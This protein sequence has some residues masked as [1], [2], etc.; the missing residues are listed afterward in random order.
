M[1]GTDREA[2][3]E[4]K[5]IAARALLNETFGSD[6][7]EKYTANGEALGYAGDRLREHHDAAREALDEIFEVMKQKSAK[8]ETAS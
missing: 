6:A 5:R 3:I 8:A 2:E 7:I 4:R 1:S